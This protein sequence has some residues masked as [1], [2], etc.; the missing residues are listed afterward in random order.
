MH[1]QVQ[2]SIFAALMGKYHGGTN[3]EA[4]RFLT[5]AMDRHITFS[6]LL[7]GFRNSHCSQLMLLTKKTAATGCPIS[8]KLSVSQ[9]R[10][11]DPIV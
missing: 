7:A 8:Q 11:D 5:V 2:M 3:V 1:I 4:Q 9:L 6:R 10:M